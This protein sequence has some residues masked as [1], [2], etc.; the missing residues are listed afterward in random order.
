MGFFGIAVTNPKRLMSWLFTGILPT[1]LHTIIDIEL[2][3]MVFHLFR[4]DNL[5][6]FFLYGWPFFAMLL[7]SILFTDYDSKLMG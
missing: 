2:V 4:G 5:L 7:V 6:P 1:F 3:C